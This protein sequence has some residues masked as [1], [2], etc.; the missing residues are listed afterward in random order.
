[1]R[2]KNVEKNIHKVRTAS[3]FIRTIETVEVAIA[4]IPVRNAVEI[5]ALE[6]RQITAAWRFF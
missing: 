2:F 1:M 3:H 5:G 6:T 4:T